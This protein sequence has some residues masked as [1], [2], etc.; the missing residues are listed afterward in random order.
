MQFKTV[1]ISLP[2]LLT[3][4]TAQ[5]YDD[6]SDLYLRE[7]DDDLDFDLYLR[8]ADSDDLLGR[9]AYDDADPDVLFRRHDSGCY[10]QRKSTATDYGLNCSTQCSTTCVKGARKKCKIGTKGKQTACSQCECAGEASA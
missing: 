1:L 9:D 8:D 2:F 7:A 3:L 6:S 5:W 4:A 10:L